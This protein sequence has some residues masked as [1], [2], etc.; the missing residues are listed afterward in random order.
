MSKRQISRLNTGLSVCS[1]MPTGGWAL[2]VKVT[3][4]SRGGI[5]YPLTLC[6]LLGSLWRNPC[7]GPDGGEGTAEGKGEF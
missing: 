4:Q 2:S 1:S 6:R 5:E 7:S 3:A